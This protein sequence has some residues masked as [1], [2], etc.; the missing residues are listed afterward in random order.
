MRIR[1]IIAAFVMLLAASAQARTVEPGTLTVAGGV[2][3]AFRLSSP[4]AAGRTYLVLQAQGEYDF[5]SSLGALADVSFGFGSSQPLRLHLGGRYRVTQLD[6]PV[7]PYAQL[8]FTLGRLYNV[9]G[10]DLT[11]VGARVGI[12]ADYFLTRKLGAGMLIA[13]DLGGTT[14]SRRAFYGT[15]DMLVYAAY[16]F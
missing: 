6:L 8:Q 1:A 12:G 15:V 2:G 3:P 4:L 16:T 5:T 10:A 7:S 13:V 9:L 14:A 11:Y